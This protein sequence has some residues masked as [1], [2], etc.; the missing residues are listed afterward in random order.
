MK[1][2]TDY[3]YRLDWKSARL[4][5]STRRLIPV[6]LL[7]ALSVA[8]AATLKVIQADRLELRTENGEELVV[9]TGN[10]VK[11]ERDGEKIEALRVIYNRTQK[12]I[13]LMGQ[14][15]LA[16]KEGRIVETEELDLSTEDDSFEA[17]EVRIQTGDITLTGPVCQ[18]AAGQILL[19]QGYLTPCLR[20]GQKTPDYA[21]RAKE[22]LL[23]P[24]DR[25]IAREVTV[26]VSE[27]PVMYLPAMLLFLSE[28]SPKVEFST[29]GQDGTTVKLDL[30]YV[31]DFGVGFTLLRYYQNRGLGLGFDHWGV[32]PAREHFFFLYTPSLF[33][34]FDGSFQYLFEY[35]LDDGGWRYEANLKRDDLRGPRR[36]SEFK[37]EASY[38]LLEPFL[39]LTLEGYLDHDVADLVDPLK[40]QKLPEAEVAFPKGLTGEFSLTGLVRA[41][42]YSA[43]TNP[44]NPS[45]AK[46]G[47][48]ISAG[49]LLFEHN[50][51]YR[52]R[53]LW[54]GF[55]ISLQNRFQG[56]YYTTQNPDG[57]YER[58]IVW[59]SQ[60][61]ASQTVGP[62]TFGIAANRELREGENP[63]RGID[64]LI[65]R[66]T[67]RAG[68][69]ASL[70]FRPEA[71][72]SLSA[73]ISKDLEQNRYG[74]LELS[75][76]L[77]PDPA[78][79]LSASAARDLELDRYDELR[80]TFSTLGIFTASLGYKRDERG[81]EKFEQLAADLQLTPRP[82]TFRATTSYNYVK[83]EYTDLTL[84]AAYA[85]LGGS[86]SLRHTRNL[87][88]GEAKTT[89]F[90][91]VLREDELG[92]T[93]QENYAHNGVA[94]V[95]N[96]APDT[97][98]LTGFVQAIWGP[99]S[100]SFEH[101]VLFVD[102]LAEGTEDLREGTAEFGLRYS[103]GA[104]NE[105]RLSGVWVYKDGYLRDPYLTF[106]LGFREPG[107]SLAVR[108]VY[109]FAEPSKPYYALEQL[110][111]EAS[112]ELV[113]APTTP[114]DSPGFGLQGRLALLRQ[115]DG[116]YAVEM[117]NFGPTLAVLADES[118][119]LLVGMFFSEKFN[120]P[121]LDGQR[122]KPKFVIIYDRCCWALRFT[123]DAK[124]NS[125]KLAFLLGGRSLEFLFRDDEV[126]LPPLTTTT[127]GGTP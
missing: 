11:M 4:V 125:F 90:S 78:F 75:L 1:G 35:R 57:E 38:R 101:R 94:S 126:I 106:R 6:L 44:L 21:F 39:R 109:H 46:Q 66:A 10:P 8:Q 63:F 13:K 61:N 52:P 108:G 105:V 41:G 54:Q 59:L 71:S 98:L 76:A 107:G 9:L 14:V 67:R 86:L 118:A 79:S 72:F 22:V 24:G 28:R 27:Q 99:Q 23:Y 81:S 55:S 15:V 45:A 77:N 36:I 42:W 83:A 20:C 110:S 17:I 33:S 96:P 53:E 12:R 84:T 7:M 3:S 124:D 62:F 19:Q 25:I 117:T 40:P 115:P 50:E 65:T 74:P 100:L 120:F 91:L 2:S 116:S 92:F 95:L 29:G 114:E 122:L 18:R 85:L 103:Y 5:T 73:K 43:Q 30:P 64:P 80:G 32:G 16:D 112:L 51:A 31:S 127:V 69:E 70:L 58:Q 49:R 56:Y 111:L 102:E 97:N 119:R 104:E 121:A 93:W 34:Q 82:F 88:T 48:Y 113:P 60:L 68:L 89:G 87:N 37:L 123:M 26:L 47:S